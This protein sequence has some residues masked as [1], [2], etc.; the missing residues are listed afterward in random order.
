M[1]NYKKKKNIVLLTD[2][3]AYL[4][5]GAER[6]IFE[7]ARRLDK[8]KYVV[9]IASLECEGR[10]P[11]D[12]IESSGCRLKVF[13]VRR[14]YGF[15]G[16]WEGLRF[17]KFLQK[18]KINILVTYHFSSDIWGTVFGRLARVRTIISNRRDMGFWRTKRH[19]WAYRIINRWV[20]KIIVVAQAISDVVCA[21]EKVPKEKIE[22]IYNGVDFQGT[23]RSST[24]FGTSKARDTNFKKSLGIETDDCVII[25]VANITPVKGH[26]FLFEAFKG[27]LKERSD[28]KLLIIGKDE[29]DGELQRRAEQL[30]IQDKVFFLG[31]RDDVPQLLKIADICVL[32][33][34]S[35]GMSNAILEYMIAGKAI[36]ATNVGGNPELVEDG[37]NGLLV[38]KEN[39]DE[40]KAALLS[41]IKDRKKRLM[42][43]K[44]GFKKVR[45]HF[46]MDRMIKN[47]QR[48]FETLSPSEVNILH[49]ISSSGLF[50][51]ENIVLTLGQYIQGSQYRSVIGALQD[52]R[53][54]KAEI[55]KRAL[56]LG[57]ETCSL[58]CHGRFDLGAV[59]RLKKYLVE[60]QIDILHTH[61]YKS[62]VI[63]FLASR[64][65]G[66]P[67]VAT[68]HG[69]TDVTRSVSLYEK[70]DRWVLRSF[71]TKVVVVT[72]KLLK[73][74]PEERKRVIANG[75][76]IKRGRVAKEI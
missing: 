28:I 58:K 65:A 25:H 11:R 43:G 76:N 39:A 41:L 55:I 72:G 33:S 71:F 18:E 51:A 36:I 6:Q 4:T 38:E 44:N 35:E 53:N 70:L 16:F 20:R 15:T 34:L 19:I 42:L 32:P 17:I 12:A 21:Q 59:F 47:Y 66:I 56:E 8:E 52:T 61:N 23:S 49:L 14:I 22:V 7:L 29:M 60:N 54:S 3:L 63:G 24:S 26:V 69:F 75:V 40:L 67:I 73:D 2:C 68:A 30:N 1:T 62:D 31:E 48:T 45:D 10:A 50:G 37:V 64:M 74:F 9:T 46:V 13:R 57:I 27:M 5:G